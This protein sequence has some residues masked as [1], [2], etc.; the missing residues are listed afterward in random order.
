MKVLLM[1]LSDPSGDPRPRRVVELC[2][3]LNFEIDLVSYPIKDLTFNYNYCFVINPKSVGRL[4]SL[5]RYF[6]LFFIFLIQKAV[7]NNFVLDFIN[8]FRFQLLA[9]NSAVEK[10]YDFIIVEDLFLLPIAHKIKGE[11][12]LIFDAREYYPKQLELSWFFRFFE[13]NE[14]YRLCRQYLIKCDYLFTVSK[15]LADE[16]LKEFGVKMEVFMS[17][18]PF[19]NCSMISNNKI[20]KIVHHGVANWNRK[21]ENMIDIVG[22]LDNKFTLDFY[23][24]GDATYIDKLKKNALK[25]TNVFFKEPVEYNNIIPTLN[26]YDVGFFY[27]EP[28]TFNLLHCLPNK[29]FEYIQANL[30]IAIGPSPDMSELVNKYDCGI[31]AKEF[32]L[33]SMIQELQKLTMSEVV[34]YKKNSS[35]AAKQLCYE[36]ESLKLINKLKQ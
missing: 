13:Q 22:G 1:C 30:M 21:L 28:T 36:V 9:I 18:P 11:A 27:V 5:W 15:G 2:N 20:I 3:D 12:K 6:Q 16:Y 4:N 32:S 29:F 33:E 23:L 14:R 25:Y 17:A 19:K 34:K 24:T 35:I 8:N 31:V 10:K 7:S 26:K